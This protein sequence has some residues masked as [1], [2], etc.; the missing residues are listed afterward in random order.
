MHSSR[1]LPVIFFTHTLVYFG[2]SED[3]YKKTF[4]TP[5]LSCVFTY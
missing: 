1:T 3:V 5:E 2:F 4:G